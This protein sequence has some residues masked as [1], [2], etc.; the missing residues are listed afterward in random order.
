M[1]T[2]LGLS[3]LLLVLVGSA[4]ALRVLRRLE[5]WAQRR[6][7]QVLILVAPLLSLTLGLGGLYHFVGRTC[8]IAAPRWD[9]WSGVALPLLM[10]LIALGGLGLG[11]IRLALLAWVLGHRGMPAS[12]GFQAL[13]EQLAARLDTPYP[14]VRICAYDRP[15]A[16]TYG[17]WRP[18]VL[19]SA[20]MIQHLDARELEAVLAHEIG[21]VARR[22]Y[23][24][25][26]LATVLRDAFCYLPT[27]WAAYTQLQHEKELACDELAV[28][29]THHPLAL[30]SALA[31]VWQ[32]ALAR[33]RA[34][35][36]QAL[37]GGGDAIEDRIHRLLNAR[38]TVVAPRT[39]AIILGL[40]F[41]GLIGL[42][43]L[44]VVNVTI[45]LA[46]MGCG[47]AAPLWRLMG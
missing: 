16:L 19:L 41:S 3:S 34:G 10:G 9:Y 33:S 27:S 39:H 1:H 11:I 28:G 38:T 42:I 6:D 25:G 20:W 21:H 37:L 30:A 4:L 12:P 18:T 24:V 26:W 40:G 45:L 7:L 43:A 22:D 17:L 46:P 31:K 8:F 32:H 13:A 47:P 29:L 5:H 44:Q 2:V 23:L 35:I 15:L 36:A 14:C